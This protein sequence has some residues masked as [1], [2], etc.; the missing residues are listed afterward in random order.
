MVVRRKAFFGAAGLAAFITVCIYGLD[1]T[2]PYWLYAVVFALSTYAIFCFAGKLSVQEKPPAA[3]SE[4]SVD[5][6]AKPRL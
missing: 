6:S 1:G 2:L 4:E 3:D 5:E